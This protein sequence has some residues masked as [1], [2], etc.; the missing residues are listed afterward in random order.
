VQLGNNSGNAGDRSWAGEG[1][2]TGRF[3][4]LRDQGVDRILF[5]PAARSDPKLDGSTYLDH[6]QQAVYYGLRK[7]D[8]EGRVQGAG[9]S[10][11]TLVSNHPLVIWYFKFG[12]NFDDA[13]RSESKSLIESLHALNR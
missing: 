1:P 11:Y 13:L 4:S 5:H 10:S 8:A 3:G 2:T 6:D 9:L 7:V 12:S